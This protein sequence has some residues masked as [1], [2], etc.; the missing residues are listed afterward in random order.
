MTA[1]LIKADT[2]K[3]VAVSDEVFVPLAASKLATVDS[4]VLSAACEIPALTS[5]VASLVAVSLVVWL[6]VETWLT[7][8][9]D[10]TPSVATPLKIS[11]AITASLSEVARKVASE[12]VATS[13]CSSAKAWP[14]KTKLAPKRTDAAPNEYLRMEKRCCSCKN[15]SR[16]ISIILFIELMLQIDCNTKRQMLQVFYKMLLNIS[17]LSTSIPNF[18]T[19]SHLN[20]KQSDF[21]HNRKK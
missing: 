13:W 21:R 9:L 7:F 2:S 11:A 8:S 10:T 4:D 15:F 18:L 12:V 19:C 17:H 5:L 20:H 16:F 3:L 1:A 6:I 14:A